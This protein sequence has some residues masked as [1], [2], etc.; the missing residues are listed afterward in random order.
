MDTHLNLKNR[1]TTTDKDDPNRTTYFENEKAIKYIKQEVRREHRILADTSV[2]YGRFIKYMLYLVLY[3]FFIGPTA[4][5]LVLIFEKYPDAIFYNLHMWRMSFKCLNNF[6]LAIIHIFI[7]YTY[8]QL[9]SQIFFIYPVVFIYI[10]NLIAQVLFMTEKELDSFNSQQISKRAASVYEGSYLETQTE[11]LGRIRRTEIIDE[12]ISNCLKLGFIDVRSFDLLLYCP[13]SMKDKQPISVQSLLNSMPTRIRGLE[14]YAVKGFEL[15]KAIVISEIVSKKNIFKSKGVV[16]LLLIAVYVLSACGISIYSLIVLI[17]V[18]WD[19]RFP[20]YVAKLI[21]VLFK[22]LL[23]WVGIVRLLIF[24]SVF[25]NLVEKLNL[26]QQLSNLANI[27]KPK[28]AKIAFTDRKT[29]NSYMGLLSLQYHFCK[30]DIHKIELMM[31]CLTV[32]SVFNLVLFYLDSFGWIKLD[33]GV[34]RNFFHLAVFADIG[35]FLIFIVTCVLITSAYNTNYSKVKDSLMA[36]RRVFIDLEINGDSYELNKEIRS[37]DSSKLYDDLISPTDTI[38]DELRYQQPQNS[39][40]QDSR[41]SSVIEKF[42]EEVAAFGGEYYHYIIC[43][44]VRYYLTQDGNQEPLK[45]KLDKLKG[46]INLMIEEI[47]KQK[48]THCFKFFWVP[49]K[50][51]TALKILAFAITITLDLFRRVLK[52]F[53]HLD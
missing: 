42:E 39:E 44:L 13:F 50:Y 51:S 12:Q 20:K 53:L 19:E 36:I 25:Y 24:K 2:K 23:G 18:K 47:D 48:S 14:I 49:L 38:K 1:A 46:D 4:M 3:L 29:L 52:E 45:S 30:R 26:F 22:I 41:E 10:V 31:G 15:F 43:N 7:L 27:K 17:D 6:C 40:Q 11:Q 8:P 9:I 35:T 16:V 5:V 33:I 32:A 34:Y 37:L 21:A 28:L